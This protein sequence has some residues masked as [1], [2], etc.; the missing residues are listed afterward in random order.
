MVG[1]VIA[2]PYVGRKKGEF[3]RTANRHDYAVEAFYRKR[4]W[5][6]LK[7]ASCDVISIGKIKDIF[8]GEGIT[9]AY[10][11]KSSL[12]GM[13][14]TIEAAGERISRTLLCESGGF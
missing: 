6:T 5:M 11:S 12:H 8:D 2:R 4:F 13:E 14:Q 9:R 3:K 1:R 7:E 10:K